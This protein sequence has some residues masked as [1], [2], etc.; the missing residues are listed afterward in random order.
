MPRVFEKSMTRSGAMMIFEVWSRVGESCYQ[1]FDVPRALFPAEILVSEHGDVT[2]YIDPNAI[3]MLPELMDKVLVDD[4]EYFHRIFDEYS[5][6]LDELIPIWDRNE[7]LD[8]ESLTK[9]LDIFS[10]GWRGLDWAYYIPTIESLSARVRDRALELRHKGERF[11]DASDAIIRKSLIALYPGIANIHYLTRKEFD[12]GAVPNEALLEERAYLYALIGGEIVSELEIDALDICYKNPTDGIV[13]EPGLTREGPLVCFQYE[14]LADEG[15]YQDIGVPPAVRPVELITCRNGLFTCC[16]RLDADKYFFPCNAMNAKNHPE[17][18][19]QMF[20]EYGE[21]LESLEKMLNAD[22]T[23]SRS[24]LLKA[25]ALEKRSCRGLFHSYCLPSVAGVSEIMKARALEYRKMEDKIGFRTRNRIR[26]T[27][28]LMYSDCP[29][30][31]FASYNEIV[32]DAIPAAEIL[33]RRQKECCIVNGELLDGTIDEFLGQTDSRIDEEKH[34]YVKEIIGRSGF[35]GIARGKARII[36]KLE[37]FESF[38]DGEI[39]VT[40]MTTPNYLPLLK[41]ASAFIT[42]EGGITCH[43]AIVAREL[44]KPCIIGTKIATKVLKDGDVVEVNADNGT[45]KIL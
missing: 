6:V 30:I 32:N 37:Q 35:P 22:R 42:D 28:E 17:F 24:E 10:R 36:T 23:W 33:E 19:D 21:I 20:A 11:F 34:E 9:F 13:Y 40:F 14:S 7:T 44:K 38:Q 3:G 31:R 43:A 15:A 8:R 41:K 27:L 4:P 18:Y 29:L 16:W 26:E 2:E 1:E 5:V 25:L 45:V 12:S 39:L